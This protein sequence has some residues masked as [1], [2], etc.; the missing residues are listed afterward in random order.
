MENAKYTPD[1]IYVLEDC[2]ENGFF[3]GDDA[4]GQQAVYATAPKGM[5]KE[6][7][8]KVAAAYNN[9]DAML[10]ALEG[11]LNNEWQVLAQRDL[12][13]MKRVK[14][15]QTAIANARKE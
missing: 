9:F 10:E 14:K 15:A 2:T 11:L 12:E 3:L 1:K 8:D 13:V 5:T 6:F 7:A 4:D